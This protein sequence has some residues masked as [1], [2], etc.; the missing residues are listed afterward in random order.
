[1]AISALTITPQRTK[2]GRVR[3]NRFDTMVPDIDDL[4]EAIQVIAY[5]EA[6]GQS[7]LNNPVSNIVVD[8]SKSKS[9]RQVQKRIQ[10]FFVDYSIVGEAAFEMYRVLHSLTRKKTGRARASYEFRIVKGI[11]DETGR[12]IGNAKS[13]SKTRLVEEAKLLERH[14]RIVVVGPLTDY[15]RKLYWNP[16]NRT[17]RGKEVAYKKRA[18]TILN[19]EANVRGK[20]NEKDGYNQSLIFIALRR[21]RRRFPGV[22]FTERWVKGDSVGTS[23]GKDRWPGVA[24]RANQKGRLI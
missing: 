13:V 4:Q 8:G 20:G 16:K 18:R 17:V 23:R 3:K 6:K 11:G 1:M 19:V 24:V 15:G 21:V 12:R 7:K 5:Q 9:P 14:E 2:K 22:Q 10:L